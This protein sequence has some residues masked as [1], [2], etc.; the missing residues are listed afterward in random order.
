ME[1]W[2]KPINLK[3]V[4]PVEGVPGI[5]RYTLAYNKDSMLCLFKMKKGSQIPLHNHIHTQNG[6]CVKGEIRFFTKKGEF[7][8]KAGDSYIFNSNE[9]HG[10]E[11]LADTDVIEVFVPCR[12]EYIPKDKK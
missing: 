6:Y 4:K 10:A 12:D 2:S 1:T 7:I 11:V 3:D 5:F 9:A 8:A